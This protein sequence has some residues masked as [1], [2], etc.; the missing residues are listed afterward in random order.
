MHT[1]R[2]VP[3]YIIHLHRHI[4]HSVTHT[5]PI[6]T[7]TYRSMHMCSHINTHTN[8]HMHLE[9]RKWGFRR[10]EHHVKN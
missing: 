7:Y 3:I 10:E 9:L 6:P 2:D 8:T 4:V 5:T 1:Y